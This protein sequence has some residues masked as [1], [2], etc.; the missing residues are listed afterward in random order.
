MIKKIKI[1]FAIDYFAVGGAPM[2]VLNQLKNLN[3]DWFD[4]YLLVLYQTDKPTFFN[5]LGLS[6][7]RIFQLNLKNRRP[8]DFKTWRQIYKILRREKFAVVYTHLFLTN[9]I[10]RIVAILTRV[11]VI[12]SFEHSAYTNKRLWQILAD[13][14]LSLFTD[15]IIV[16]T[17]S[18]GSF[19]AKQEKIS[20]KKFAVITNPVF[21]PEKDKVDVSRIRKELNLSPD[22]FVVI[23]LGRFSEEKGFEYFL[24]AAEKVSKL[25]K[26]ICFL[27]VGYGG[28][29]KKLNQ[30]IIELGLQDKCRLI[31]DPKRAK[32]YLYIGDLFVLPSLREGQSI[33]TYEAMAAGLPVIASRLDGIRDII[34]DGRNGILIEP[35]DSLTMAEK[36]VY[37]YNNPLTR[38]KFITFGK[39][40]I[41]NF[42]IKKNL[43]EFEDLIRSLTTNENT[44]T[45]KKMTY[46]ANVR[47]PT[48]KAYGVQMIKMCEA[49]AKF[50]E[51]ISLVV[52]Q[53]VNKLTG[54]IHDF[55]QVDKNFKIFKLPFW[56]YK[57][58]Y[59][60]K[61]GFFIQTM[62]FL[63]TVKLFFIRQ[64]P[65]I[66][67]TREPLVGL[68]FKDFILELHSLP[69]KI[70]AWHRWLWRRPHRLIV[71]TS[72]IKKELVASGV[73]A[74]NILVSPDGVDLDEFSIG[75]DKE[76]ARKKLNL[77][78]DKKIILYTGH[79]YEWK[80]AQ[81]LALAANFLSIGCLIIF[82]GGIEADA[83]TF[84]EKNQE[85][86][87]LGKIVIYKHQP[88]NLIPAW[89]KAADVLV[90]P[91]KSKEKISKYYTSPLKLFEYMAGH[92]PI[93]ASDLPSIR[94]VLDESNCLF[95]EPD[96]PADLAEKIKRILADNELAEKISK[97]AY[98]DV[99]KYTWNKRAEKI[100]E[101]IK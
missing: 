25:I 51:K 98:E 62:L 69:E 77:P 46:L 37:L 19:T 84:K 67:Y 55:Y 2:V 33:V 28:L 16:S 43:E 90:L 41:K 70:T 64:H 20:I 79:L 14:L 80:G 29:E 99:K 5:E 52:P 10:V 50:V 78:L 95:Y 54:E 18:V 61:M 87:K 49:L 15:K 71:L 21:L 39:E 24:Q 72:F 13:K 53:K 56:D 26:N 60:Y 27:L 66:I 73:L 101:F 48:E 42:D 68:F 44:V 76:L 9:L 38:Q 59:K 85:L 11:P 23:T 93:V 89:L 63:I 74:D 57:L 83:A 32:E 30:R 75:L 7:D 92:R 17:K 65:G 34:E 91:N 12:V 81:D 100:V 3:R 96:N 97:Q 82:V 8:L 22:C 4:P 88:H 47:I 1:L 45:S 58:L 36:I 35:K 40:K 94:E 31:V 6:S 86:I